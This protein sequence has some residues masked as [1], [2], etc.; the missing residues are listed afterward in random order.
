[1]FYY[2]PNAHTNIQIYNINTHNK[3]FKTKSYIH[4]H[5]K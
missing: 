2:V 3:A 1:M 4:N 5:K